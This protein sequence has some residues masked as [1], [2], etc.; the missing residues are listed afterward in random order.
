MPTTKRLFTDET[1]QALVTA[2]NNI[3]AAVKPNAT[4]IQMSS[5]DTTTVATAITN[6]NN[7]LTP[8][9]LKNGNI[10]TYFE[11]DICWIQSA[12]SSGSQPGFNYYQ[13]EIIPN[14]NGQ[15]VQRATE[16][17]NSRIANRL[18][19]NGAWSSWE[20][21]AFSR[22]ITALNSKIETG[23]DFDFT[24]NSSQTSRFAI[25]KMR[26]KIF[27]DIYIF[28]LV[29]NPLDAIDTGEIQL[30]EVSVAPGL[31]TATVATRNSDTK[32]VGGANLLENKKLYLRLTESVNQ[33]NLIYIS[34]A[35]TYR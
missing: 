28:C 11:Q 4:E 29:L 35:S 21:V 12:S 3:V 23:T 20:P 13:L 10:D 24:L 14:G 27:G 6:I 1:G 7:K 17:S 31:N 5:S 18:Y 16:M 2:I 32:P 9:G 22:E 8:S 25:N 34:F 26:A 33:G 19:A 30:G 15:V